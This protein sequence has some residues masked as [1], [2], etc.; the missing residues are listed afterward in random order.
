MR[1]NAKGANACVKKEAYENMEDVAL[2]GRDAFYFGPEVR[3]M[4]MWGRNCSS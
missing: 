4:K 1:R 2:N 3:T